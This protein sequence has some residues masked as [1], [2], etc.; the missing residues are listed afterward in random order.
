MTNLLHIDASVRSFLGEGEKHSSISK[1]LGHLFITDWKKQHPHD[2]ITYRD[3][4]EDTPNF[5]SQDWLGAVF[6]P[7]EKRTQVHKMILSESD[8]YIN[9]VA[10]ADI[11]LITTPMYNYGMP[12]AL[13]AWFDQ[14]IRINKT[15]TFDLARGDFPLAPIF[16]NKTLILLNSC[17]EFGFGDGEIREHMNHL[18]THI[19][20]LSH[21]L[22]VNQFFE[23]RSE[24]QEFGD[25]R[26]RDSLNAAK[27]Q[28]RQLVLELSQDQTKAKLTA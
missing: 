2:P 23:I 13:K 20:V 7:E 14:I 3:L 15:F 24:Y 1:M 6:T 16:S 9:E 8:Q 25:Q 4:A 27:H 10:I 12:A 18:G 21:Y 19:K 28:V 22:G 11:I 17:G 5:I 26:H